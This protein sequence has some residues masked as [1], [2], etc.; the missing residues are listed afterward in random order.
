MVDRKI[1][2]LADLI[3]LPPSA[4]YQPRLDQSLSRERCFLC[5]ALLVTGADSGE[6]VFPKWLQ[7]RFDLWNHQLGLP[8]GTLIRYRDIKVPCCRECNNK[9]L[10]SLEEA[11]ADMTT[12]TRGE[13]LKSN[14]AMMAIYLWTAKI[15]YCLRF[16]ELFMEAE[17]SAPGSGTIAVPEQ[18]DDM[19]YLH[20]LLQVIRGKARI[21]QSSIGMWVFDCQD[22]LDGPH[23]GFDLMDL[24][25]PHFMSMRIGHLAFV[26]PF[27]PFS[28]DEFDPEYPHIL[29]LA[30]QNVLHPVQWAEVSAM[31][32]LDHARH[33]KELE[34]VGRPS[35]GITYLT[36]KVHERERIDFNKSEFLE[37]RDWMF[38]ERGSVVVACDD[39]PPVSSIVGPAGEFNELPI[40][41]TSFGGRCSHFTDEQAIAAIE[42]LVKPDS[43]NPSA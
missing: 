23:G 18:M 3:D 29:G 15:Y 36:T 33:H 12:A 14:T 17:R 22:H 13:L 11:V 34:T 43:A 20:G 24:D 41:I 40:T 32:A 28:F 5:G 21:E 25:W 16:K 2:R 27:Q 7:H 1:H 9:H 10:S 19:R 39:C 30:V 38:R 42:E 35:G 4:Y 37:K 31:L 6:H 8:N 26:V